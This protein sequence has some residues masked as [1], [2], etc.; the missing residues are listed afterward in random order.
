MELSPVIERIRMF[1]QPQKEH[2]GNWSLQ[3]DGKKQ[4]FS[5]SNRKLGLS[6]GKPASNLEELLANGGIVTTERELGKALFPELWEQV[7]A[8]YEPD[9]RTIEYL[10]NVKRKIGYLETKR[11]YDTIKFEPVESYQLGIGLIGPVPVE[12]GE[13]EGKWVA[14]YSY[15][16]DID[17]YVVVHHF[18]SRRP[19]FKD[20][21]TARLIDRIEM[22]FEDQWQRVQFRCWECG[23]EK[24]WLDVPG[25]LKEKWEHYQERYCGC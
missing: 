13:Y 24:H 6:F 25:S 22:Y 16:T 4:F 2:S 8:N 20:I 11:G 18:F 17:D 1:Y 19:C 15:Q 10:R 21:E 12:I 5:F 3:V 9:K 14:E 23:C 7:R